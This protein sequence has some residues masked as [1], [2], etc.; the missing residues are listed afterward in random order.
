ME[1]S[2]A[3]EARDAADASGPSANVWSASTLLRRPPN[4]PVPDFAAPEAADDR[5]W[6]CLRIRSPARRATPA[7]GFAGTDAA[8]VARPVQLLQQQAAPGRAGKA[9]LRAGAISVTGE[10]ADSPAHHGAVTSIPL[11]LSQSQAGTLA[12]LSVAERVG[13][14]SRGEALHGTIY[15]VIIHPAI[16]AFAYISPRLLFMLAREILVI[17]FQWILKWM[18]L[19]AILLPASAGLNP[20]SALGAGSGGRAPWLDR[21]WAS[22]N[23]LTASGEGLKAAAEGAAAANDAIAAAAGLNLGRTTALPTGAGGGGGDGGGGGGG[24]GG[25][26][27]GGGGGDGRNGTGVGGTGFPAGFGAN[28]MIGI[29]AEPVWPDPSVHWSKDPN[30]EGHGVTAA[31]ATALTRDPTWDHVCFLCDQKRLYC[32]QCAA[33]KEHT[34]RVGWRASYYGRYYAAYHL[35][36]WAKLVGW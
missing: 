12:L 9:S 7:E 33:G 28:G 19:D 31:I 22:I 2:L 32:A 23:D 18:L 10:T 4:S 35:G 20:A 21:A 11:R 27:G 17:L 1:A 30:R 25:G 8:D 13:A 16:N 36:L 26:G 6:R 29:A 5:V 3:R 15:E 34:A 14:L 24:R